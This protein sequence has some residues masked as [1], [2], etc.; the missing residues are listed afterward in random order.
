[1]SVHACRLITL[2]Q[3]FAVP[4]PTTDPQQE[5]LRNLCCAPVPGPPPSGEGDAQRHAGQHPA[6]SPSFLWFKVTAVEP[7]EPMPL[8]VDPQTTAVN[9]EVFS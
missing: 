5:L 3:L 6:P 2:G 4:D 9:I 7:H 8:A 1:M